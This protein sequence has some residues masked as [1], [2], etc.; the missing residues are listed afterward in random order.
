MGPQKVHRINRCRAHTALEGGWRYE[1]QDQGQIVQLSGSRSDALATLSLNVQ[2]GG[3]EGGRQPSVVTA[4][5]ACSLLAGAA[6]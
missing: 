3:E 6:P 4:A 5:H 1:A 2:L